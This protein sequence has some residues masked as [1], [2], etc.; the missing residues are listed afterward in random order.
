M[1][2][3]IDANPADAGGDHAA[4]ADR[5]PLSSILDAAS[6]GI[7]ILG[8][9]GRPVYAN[10]AFSTTPLHDARSGS[11]EGAFRRRHFRVPL[12]GETYDVSLSLDESEQHRLERDLMQRAYFDEL[13]ELP[14][15]SLFQQ[16]I[17]ALADAGDT[18]FAVAFIDLDGFKHVN[19]YYGHAVGDGLLRGFA[20][21]LSATLRP[22]DLLARLAGD[23]FA[24]LI[25]P[26]G[27]A[28]EL[29]RDLNWMAE[30]IKQPFVVDGHEIFTSASIGVSLYPRDGDSCERL[31][32]N[33]DR[34]MYWGKSSAKG[35]VRFCDASIEHAAAQKSRLEQRLRLAIRDKRV[36]CAFQPK[37]DLRS[38][39]VAGLEVLMRWIDEDGIIQPPGD[40]L[41]L[42][43]ELGLMDDLTH[44]ILGETVASI[45]RINAAF[46]RDCSISV[47][48]AAK[49]AGDFDFMRSLVDALA[50]TG[51]AERFMLELT[52]EAFLSKGEFQTRILPMVRE[53]GSRISIDDFGV[54]YSSLSALADITADEVKVDRSFVTDVHRRPRSQ[55]ILKAIEALG[56][57]LG[58]T[59]VVEG[60]ETFEELAFLQAATRI[61]YAQGYYFSKAVL[62]EE[63]GSESLV[64]T[65]ARS[66]TA[67]RETVATR[68]AQLRSRGL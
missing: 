34:A 54:G 60:V 19:D 43:V 57:S 55:S 5:D 33:A 44:F 42:A 61:N 32:S 38:G 48:V 13:T 8:P 47:N 2:F 64:R 28:D 16:S 56:H 18:A 49:Q 51:F 39:S 1:S 59:V 68:G 46:G 4:A 9:D 10:A 36:R 27:D 58:M 29:A 11:G 17:N 12:A 45:D 65:G 50:A 14:G 24:M 35:Q 63:L 31:L 6:F 53:I 67:G 40:F 15:R 26:V 22:S 30:R 23:E 66:A 62:L 52:E 25:A 41:A 37:V 20:Q 3:R 21:R 7:E